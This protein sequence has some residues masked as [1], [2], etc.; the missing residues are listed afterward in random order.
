MR[1]L[2]PALPKSLA[3]LNIALRSC[4]RGLHRSLKLANLDFSNALPSLVAISI[5][6]DSGLLF[7]PLEIDDL[8]DTLPPIE[9]LR[10]L[11]LPIQFKGKEDVEELARLFPRLEIIRTASFDDEEDR[12]FRSKDTAAAVVE[13][14]RR[15]LQARQLFLFG[16]NLAAKRPAV[17]ATLPRI[18]DFRFGCGPAATGDILSTTFGCSLDCQV[19]LESCAL[20]KIW[21]DNLFAGADR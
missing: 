10:C 2:W 11:G 4:D 19:V 8:H 14:G 16:A 7:K 12:S 9:T 5:C 18:T 20:P 3:S 13:F 17:E 1:N 15:G 6:Y 21:S